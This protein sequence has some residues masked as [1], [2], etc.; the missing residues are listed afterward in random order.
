MLIE[1]IDHLDGGASV[2]DFAPTTR[3][4]E[5]CQLLAREA[6]A[7]RVQ[8]RRR[9]SQDLAL[10]AGAARPRATGALAVRP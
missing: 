1:Q 4:H 10:L 6:A 5:V 9:S 7:D 2:G 8:L 3:N